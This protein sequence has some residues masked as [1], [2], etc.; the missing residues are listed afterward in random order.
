MPR[1]R[2]KLAR[3]LVFQVVNFRAIRARSSGTRQ[4][5]GDGGMRG[6]LAIGLEWIVMRYPRQMAVI[7]SIRP[8]L[9]RSRRN[10]G[11]YE[12]RTDRCS[13]ELHLAMPF[14]LR[15]PGHRLFFYRGCRA[16]RLGRKRRQLFPVGV[17]T[18][19]CAIIDHD[20]PIHLLRC[21]LWPEQPQKPALLRMILELEERAVQQTAPGQADLVAACPAQSSLIVSQFRQGFPD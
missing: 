2:Q 11:Q 4:I 9:G 18:G 10:R 13:E 14:R 7:W 1:L 12:R 5:H 16:E 20:N 8:R 6:G 19:G 17:R 3:G 15:M 21:K